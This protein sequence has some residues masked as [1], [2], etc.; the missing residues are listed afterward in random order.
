VSKPILARIA[1]GDRA[2]VEE[3]Y[4][5][6]GGLVW[7]L[8]R[9]LSPSPA[10]A[11]D[12]VQEIFIDVWKSAG[13]YD[14]MQASEAGFVA[15]LARRRLIDRHRR[16]R[17]QP[18]LEEL[19]DVHEDTTGAHDARLE[20]CAEAESARRALDGLREEQRT[21]L[22][23]ALVEGFTH[24]EISRKTGMPLGTVKTHARRGL[25]AVREQILAGRGAGAGA[26]VP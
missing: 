10:E 6:F 23:L 16:F 19:T 18:R 22:E 12:A 4:D 20:L 13:R 21:V 24:D 8:A 11:E 5:A 3:C 25:I 9:R 26:R 17:R 1:N 14:A 15:M 2:A 7:S